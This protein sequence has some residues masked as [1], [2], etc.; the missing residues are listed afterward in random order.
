M[1][2]EPKTDLT[3][4][5]QAIQTARAWVDKF[6]LYLDTETTGLGSEAQIIDIAVVDASGQIILNTLIKPTC[7]IPAEATAIHGITDEMV[8]RA[9]SFDVL[10]PFLFALLQKRTV[11]TFNADYDF[12]LIEQSA[13]AWE[14]VRESLD[15]DVCQCCAMTLYAQYYGDW[16]DFR[17]NYKWQSLANAA[18]QCKIPWAP[19][20]AHRALADTLMARE[21]MLHMA[22]EWKDNDNHINDPS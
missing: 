18:R 22:N 13:T 10:W 7:L 4:R 14:Y 8:A 20:T 15:R 5:Q 19:G 21:V 12:R 9:P 17:G 16:N 11:I 1:I 2:T 6:P 3:D